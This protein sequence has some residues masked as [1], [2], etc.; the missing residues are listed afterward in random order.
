MKRSMMT[1]ASRRLGFIVLLLATSAGCV[2]G[3]QNETA[4]TLSSDVERCRASFEC[5]EYGLCSPTEGVCAALSDADCERGRACERYG[6]CVARVG[7]CVSAPRPSCRA[8][9]SERNDW[10]PGGECDAQPANGV[11]S[12]PVRDDAAC[13]SP[14]PGAIGD[15][16]SIDG[17]CHMQDGFCTA[18]EDREC[19]VSE[20]CKRD[21]HCVAR[22]GLCVAESAEACRAAPA[23]RDESRCT[24]GVSRCYAT[25]ADCAATKA[26][27]DDPRACKAEHGSCSNPMPFIYFQ[28]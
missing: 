4:S 22:A 28:F 19:R 26:C 25:D 20:G 1:Q 14:R 23:C 27:R 16:C 12:V 5:L 18:K 15:P 9:G 13:R 17:L 7:R 11:C 10:C 6:V 21:G 24:R 3:A 8:S 2:R